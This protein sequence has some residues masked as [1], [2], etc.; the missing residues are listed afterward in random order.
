MDL[1]VALSGAAALDGSGAVTFTIDFANSASVNTVGAT[2]AADFGDAMLTQ[3]KPLVAPSPLTVTL[4]PPSA[5]RSQLPWKP[6][7][8]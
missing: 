3:H 6:L 1:V 7:T 2:S 4:Q 8:P 5:V